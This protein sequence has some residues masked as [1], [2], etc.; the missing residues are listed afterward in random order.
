MA[1]IIVAIIVN[2]KIVLYYFVGYIMQTQETF[3]NKIR[4]T[5]KL[6]G[7]DGF[8]KGVAL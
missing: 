4:A 3:I 6:T 1:T 5:Y 8:Q 7:A 2:A